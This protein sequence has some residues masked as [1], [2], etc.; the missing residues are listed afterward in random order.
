MYFICNFSS[1]EYAQQFDKCSKHFMQVD[2]TCCSILSTYGTLRDWGKLVVHTFSYLTKKLSSGVSDGKKWDRRLW[3]M[4]GFVFCGGL[5]LFF[6]VVFVLNNS[7]TCTITGGP[8]SIF[9][10]ICS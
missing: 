7:F 8:N 2:F 6:V 9:H 4:V 1:A 10:S 5:L 3:G